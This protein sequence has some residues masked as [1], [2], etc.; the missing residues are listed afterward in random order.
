[1]NKNI[2]AVALA[3]LLVGG[4]AVAAFNSFSNKGTAPAASADGQLLPGQDGDTAANG[5]IDANKVEYADVTNVKS[6]TE[7]EKLYAT[8]IGS[9]AIRETSTTSTPREV[10]EDVVVQERAPERDGNVGGTVAG[11]V[12]GGLLGNQVGG[13]NGKKAA[14][15]GGAVAGGFIG[16]QIDK[17]HVGG[18]VTSRTE[19]QCHTVSSTS[20]SSRV[21]GYN[22]TYR[23]PDGT[24]GTMRTDSK[25]GS[26][27]LLGDEDKVVGYDV[28][29]RYNG[30]EQT[31]R[32]DERP[33]AGRLPVIDGQ[34]VTQTA[35][36]SA[37]TRG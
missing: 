22:V 11:A 6:I 23:N 1:M 33:V 17:R 12:I 18:K 13:G 19:R 35:S 26:R 9:D 7:K 10:C 16:N 8:V 31:I 14:T 2:L 30:A 4:V 20:E 32:M 15:V 36:A 5:A 37:P 21:V 29:Y 25:P 24:T 3:S 34:V 28:T 27:I